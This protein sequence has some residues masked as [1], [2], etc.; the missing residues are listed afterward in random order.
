MISTYVSFHEGR[1]RAYHLT[2]NNNNFARLHPKNTS[3][4]D[5]MLR[6][7]LNAMLAHMSLARKKEQKNHIPQHLPTNQS[8][9]LGHCI[10]NSHTGV[11]TICSKGKQV[12]LLIYTKQRKPLLDLCNEGHHDQLI[13]GMVQQHGFRI[14][15]T[16]NLTEHTST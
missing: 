15:S 3:V 14:P 8:I 16:S 12:D 4:G 5:L 7:S 6:R 10:S 11:A 9:M 2:E 1:E 13:T